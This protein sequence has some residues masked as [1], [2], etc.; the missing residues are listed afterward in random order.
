MAQQQVVSQEPVQHPFTK[1]QESQLAK[2]ENMLKYLITPKRR[3]YHDHR[4]T[5]TWDKVHGNEELEAEI[6]R[7]LKCSYPSKPN[8]TR[9]KS[10]P[11]EK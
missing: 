6:S 7:F 11:K 10:R 5:V 3:V 9:Q 2:G 1:T 8:I 4:A